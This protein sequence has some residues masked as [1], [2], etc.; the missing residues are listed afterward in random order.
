MGHFLVTGGCGFVG[1]ALSLALVENGHD[2][3]ILDDLSVGRAEDAPDT[4]ELLVGDV[5]DPDTVSRAMAG[6]DGCFHLAAIAS[7]ARCTREWLT[8]SRVNLSGTLAVF[9]AAYHAGRG[10]PLPVVYASSAAVY[11]EAGSQ[12]VSEDAPLAPTSP[13]GADKAACEMHARAA[14]QIR[15]APFVGVRSFNVYGSHQQLLPDAG[16][17]VHFAEAMAAGRTIDIHGDGTQ[18]RD[19]VHVDDVVRAFMIAMDDIDRAPAV[20]NVC[21]GV[22]TTLNELVA[23]LERAFDTT[24]KI[25][26]VGAREGDIHV[27]LGDPRLAGHT[28]G[29]EAKID[30]D[31]G[32]RQLAAAMRTRT[33]K[34]A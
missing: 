31:T 22:A 27:S 17:I 11:G 1:S 7:V 28:L 8:G 16:V 9:E 6:M 33:V 29:F 13:Y 25:R 32:L 2:V 15:Q 30:L 24:A 14:A 12:P 5:A 19:F 20:F 4:A 10:T 23:G 18:S 3:R 26:R 34:A 21:T